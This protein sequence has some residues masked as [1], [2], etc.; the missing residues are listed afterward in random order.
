MLKHDLRED[1]GILTLHPEGPLESADF[2]ALASD[3]DAYLARHGTLR[4]VL[5]CAKSF[6]GWKDFGALLA[7]LKFLK[8][9]LQRIEKVAVVADGTM[10]N[11]MPNIA[12][13]FVHA[14]V[15]H[16]DFAREDAAWAW[17]KQTGSAQMRP[18]A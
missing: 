6:P 1:D 9:H 13:H 3:V 12:N 18:A 7:H 8:K 5:I 10:A 2:A 16:F 15:Q 4:G 17:L 11:I 14:Q